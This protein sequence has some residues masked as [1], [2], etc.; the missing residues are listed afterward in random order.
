M[1][2]GVRQPHGGARGRRVRQ[3]QVVG[4]HDVRDHHLHDRRHVEAAGAGARDGAPEGEALARVRQAGGR[5][6]RAALGAHEAAAVEAQRVLVV[7][8]VAHE[9]LLRDADPG[10]AGHG[11][12]VGEGVVALDL[13]VDGDG[14]QRVG[15][16]RLLDEAVEQRRVG[17][18]GAEERLP[19]RARDLLAQHVHVLRVLAEA[20]QDERDEHGHLMRGRE[21]QAEHKL[22]HALDAVLR[23]ALPDVHDELDAVERLA[24]GL[25]AIDFV[26]HPLLNHLSDLRVELL[27][28]A[29]PAHQHVADHRVPRG[30]K[31]S[32]NLGGHGGV[33]RV[34]P[35]GLGDLGDR[36]QLRPQNVHRV[37]GACDVERHAIYRKRHPAVALGLLLYLLGEGAPERGF[38]T[39][40]KA[41]KA[42]PHL[43]AHC[44]HGCPIMGIRRIVRES[45]KRVLG[46]E[47]VVEEA[48][49]GQVVGLGVREL[50]QM[51]RTRNQEVIVGERRQRKRLPLGLLV[52]FGHHL[53]LVEHLLERGDPCSDDC[54]GSHQRVA[55]L[56]ES[57]GSS[58]CISLIAYP[59]LELI[60]RKNVVDPG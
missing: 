29:A 38:Q 45:V 18:G 57:A 32:Q 51:L 52:G 48:V 41:R 39:L 30:R 21:D 36:R 35:C 34:S 43:S 55:D 9:R 10:A 20:Q 31:E 54:R 6:G 2:H 53:G 37:H 56:L 27:H 4:A 15:A 50:S 23:G 7:P 17:L 24:F 1:R 14:L 60:L 40:V 8:R 3:A 12:A 28:R 11:E 5:D 42:G 16:R 44:M 22:R 47:G 59:S 13:A 25:G 58:S 46:K 33:F 19:R 26:L 49:H